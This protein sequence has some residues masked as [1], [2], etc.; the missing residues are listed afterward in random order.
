MVQFHIMGMITGLLATILALTIVNNAP[1][2]SDFL[3]LKADMPYKIQNNIN[4]TTK[5][6][7][8]IYGN[9]T[10]SHFY[11]LS[12]LPPRNINKFKLNKLGVKM[13]KNTNI[14]DISV[15]PIRNSTNFNHTYCYGGNCYTEN[16]TIYEYANISSDIDT[17]TYRSYILRLDT[18]AYMSD[19]FTLTDLG[20][21]PLVSEEAS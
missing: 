8:E 17:G 16:Y 2:D 6:Y 4:I 10:S 20:V 13:E 21:D 19:N 12:I 3:V 11:V 7:N 9:G 5:D 1:A 14:I 18:P 15:Y